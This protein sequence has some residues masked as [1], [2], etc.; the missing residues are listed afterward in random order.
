MDQRKRIGVLFNTGKYWIGGVYYILNIIKSLEY[1]DDK[2]KPMLIIFYNDYSESFLKNITYEYKEFVFH[3]SN[4]RKPSYFLQSWISGKNAFVKNIISDYQL[5][6]LFPL[7]DYPVK[8]KKT[9]CVVAAWY[10]D[11][12]HKFYPNYF[13]P[14]KL[15][16]REMRLQFLLK[17]AN[18]LVVSSNDTLS[19]F[20]RFYSLPERI[21]THLLQFVS[22]MDDINFQD[23]EI[24]K[25]KY[26]ISRPYFIVSNTFYEHK[27]HMVVF[28]AIKLLLEKNIDC[29]VIFTGK[30]VG[31]N[32]P[33]FVD[34][35]VQ[36][37]KDNN[38]ENSA[39]L[40]GTIPRDEQLTLM[41]HALAVIQ[42]SM[43]EGWS[44]V[45][46]DAKSLQTQI[47]SSNINVHLEQL[48]NNAHFFDPEDVE[49]LA[50][51]I[52]AFQDGQIKLLPVWNDQEKR[53][54]SFAVN[55]LNIFKK[56]VL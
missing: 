31:C 39:R 2:D 15:R 21:K 19:H 8:L 7:S 25:E 30:I 11:L 5:K 53:I 46:E 17:H 4:K 38:L 37:V 49:A 44:T 48:G 22:I 51:Y 36:Y 42:P 14:F 23:I 10:P 1:L 27:N 40:L 9:D 47:I 29:C 16:M 50:Q 34:G 6:G 33:K 24:L 55:F 18:N 43:F 20:H 35:L 12:Q 13:T 28:K 3:E 26:E 52:Q 56:G 32:N 41:K 45:I 54:K